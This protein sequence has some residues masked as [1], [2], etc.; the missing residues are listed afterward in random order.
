MGRRNGEREHGGRFSRDPLPVFSA[1]GPWEQFW[2]GQEC[3]LFDAVHPA[4]PLPTTASSTL[5]GALKD[6]FKEAVV[7]CDMPEPCKFPSLDI[8]EKR[9][10]WTHKE[11]D[12]APYPVAGPLLR[13]G[14]T[15]KFPHALGFESLDSLFLCKQGPC[16]TAVEG[17]RGDKRLTC[18]PSDNSPKSSRILLIVTLRV[19]YSYRS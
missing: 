1:G 10:L 7:V 4:F 3:S 8:C 19:A 12:L 11:V 2:H 9:F 5:R 15:E 16:F 18:L 13:L 17:G 14:N 6:G